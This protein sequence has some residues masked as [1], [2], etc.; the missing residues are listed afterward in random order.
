MPFDEK[1][2]DEAIRE[3]TSRYVPAYFLMLMM[4]KFVSSFVIGFIVARMHYTEEVLIIAVIVLA[5]LLL[6]INYLYTVVADVNPDRKFRIELAIAAL[7]LAFGGF[8]N[9][10]FFMNIG[11]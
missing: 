8:A 11:M 3:E 6:V 10:L 2:P 5:V 4:V 9:G 7:M 1:L